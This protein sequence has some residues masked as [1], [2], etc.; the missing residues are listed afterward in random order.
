MKVF[1]RKKDDHTANQDNSAVKS[2][3]NI[4]YTEDGNNKEHNKKHKGRGWLIAGIVIVAIIG[5]AFAYWFLTTR[6]PEVDNNLRGGE[7]EL[8]SSEYHEDGMYTLL[9]V[10]DDQE[11]FN[12]DTIMVM[13]FDSNNN[14]ANV[15]SI[16][17]DTMINNDDKLARKINA[18]Y[19]SDNGGID[20]L[21]NTVENIT[22]F[23]PDNYIVVDTN[24]F[25]DVINA[26]G[27]V[28]YDVPQDMDYDDY[29]DHDKDGEF[30]YVFNIHV[31]KGYQLLNGDDAL[32]VFRFRDGYAMGDIDRLNVQHDLLMKAAEQFM[33]SSNLIKLWQVASIILDNSTT[34]L[35]YGYLQ[36][37]AQQFL[38]MSID[39]ISISTMPATGV[40]VNDVAYVSI[41]VDEWME[42]LNS[43]I[44][45][46]KGD[47][48]E[49]DC[50]ILYWTNPTTPGSD[51]QYHIDPNDIAA[52][53]GSKV[54]ND[55]PFS[56]DLVQAEENRYAKD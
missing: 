36:W 33:A 49:E 22:G 53:D 9:V 56:K 11:G 2:G 37:Y 43:K 44:N 32:G 48:T 35:T 10:G 55:F 39:D 51:G 12:T 16:P 18:V 38:G 46:L 42:L 28:Y 5:C 7:V 34:D 6:A 14:T 52:T 30:E 24:C 13:R 41:N 8:P 23:H 50:P 17:R 45:P 20:S 15:V 19:H 47:I 3:D 25:V 1:G 54:Y 40:M 21:M 29:S 27:G 26:M 4:N 31:K